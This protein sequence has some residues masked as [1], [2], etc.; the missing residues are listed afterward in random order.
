VNHS[1]DALGTFLLG[2]E[3]PLTRLGLG[4]I[5]F[6]GSTDRWGPP[7]DPAQAT[8]V[9][10]AA[11]EAG[12]T[13]IDTADCYGPHACESLIAQ[14]L[15]PYDD[16]LVIATKGG[17]RRTRPDEW[18]HHGH[19][20]YLR[21]CI[22]ESLTRLRR[23]TIDLYYLHRV[24]PRIPLAEQLGALI[25]ARQRGKIR[26]IGLSKVTLAQLEHAQTL[27]PIAAVQNLNDPSAPDAAVRDYCR[28]RDIAYVPFRPFAG[29]QALQHG[30][31][32]HDALQDIYRYH[33][34]DA[35]HAL[36]IPGTTSLPHLLENIDAFTAAI[37]D[38]IT[39]Q[40]RAS[41]SGVANEHAGPREIARR[42]AAATA[43]RPHG[44]AP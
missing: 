44:I 17:I 31:P 30:K 15:H 19:P 28:R 6:T 7:A 39:D 22:D 8:D 43:P 20:D 35:P 26:H 4:T 27:T 37:T 1:R 10:R 18:E 23:D 12:I 3:I 21:A 33:L 9:L 24:D 41:S 42:P 29:G 38:T 16:T 2:G 5:H 11:L 14:A 34:N 32:K 40:L 36:L 25:N 13:H